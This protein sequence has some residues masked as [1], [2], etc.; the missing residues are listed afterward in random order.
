[1]LKDWKTKLVL[2]GLGLFL[3]LALLAAYPVA[4]LVLALTAAAAW[5][6]N[7]LGKPGVAAIVPVLAGLTGW[8]FA[9]AVDAWALTK[10]VEL[11]P[12]VWHSWLTNAPL[13][14]PANR[15]GRLGLVVG[16][17][18][19]AVLP[20]IAGWLAGWGALHGPGRV[21]GLKVAESA[22]KGTSRWA[23]ERDVAHVADFGPPREGKYGGGTIVGMFAGF[24]RTGE[25]PRPGL[26][27][28]GRIVRI[29][30]EKCVPPLPAHAAVI[31]GTGAGKSYSFVI[32]NAIAAACEGESLVV[33][34]PKGELT[35]L[36]APWL[37]TKGYE[38]YVF[39]LAR[40]S[41]GNCWNPVLEARDDEEFTA[42]ATA[43]INNAARDKSGYF[44]AKEIE[45]L[46][47][48]CYLLKYH[49]PESQAHLR[50]VMSL[51]S[52]P[53]EALDARFAAAY[54][55]G[56]LPREGH[57]AWKSASSANLDNAVSGIG[58]K[59]NV[60]RGPE[61][62]KLLSRQEIDLSAVGRRKSALFCVLPVASGH[63]RPVLAV[64]YYFFF[65]RLYGL[66]AECGGR[67]PV[68][69]RFLLDEFAN[70]GE[71]PG[72]SEVISTARSLGIKVQFVLQGLKQLNE[73]YG[74]ADAEAIMSNCP[75][76]VFLGGDD[77]TTTS[78]FSRRLGEAAVETISERQDVTVPGKHLLELPKRTKTVVRR[79]LMEPEEL[80][81]MHPLAC[82]V[83]TRWCLPAYLRKVDWRQLPQAKEIEP[84]AV[85]TPAEVV[86]ERKIELDL[87]E[88]PEGTP[89]KPPGRERGRGREGGRQKEPEPQDAESELT[90]ELLV[91][92]P[93]PEGEEEED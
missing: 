80:S 40:P 87:P 57:E 85:R 66:A 16:G 21:H 10:G 70:V 35:C 11:G 48:L 63:L 50:S 74:A 5:A 25:A 77:A 84:L 20:Y 18:I 15:A 39:N 1:M 7:R 73:V 6:G 72:F 76:Q 60:L 42:L 2:A 47:A 3:A 32:P 56:R 52:W 91:P 82:V 64:F 75:I 17:L 22:A 90:D 31:A 69:T 46:K 78:Y 45:L 34:D 68:P 19:G 53:P 65:R 71:V 30:P 92:P 4:F 93:S 27:G 8:L 28:Q 54:R 13:S 67:L 62:A 81:R 58:S 79:A 86:P 14:N 24:P 38:I 33:T 43:L 12:V 61:L 89:R 59:L 9:A 88:I 29:R 83:L 51:I 26:F 23:G 49:F 36:L 41:W 44:V 37:R 55:E